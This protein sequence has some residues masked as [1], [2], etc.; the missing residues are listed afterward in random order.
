MS[1][2]GKCR[3][4]WGMRR[5]IVDYDPLLGGMTRFNLGFVEIVQILITISAGFVIAFSILIMIYNLF[6]SAESGARGWGQPVALAFT[7]M[8][9]PVAH[10]RAQLSP[11]A[12]CGG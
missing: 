8:A 6:H 11:S 10:S 9:D 2:W 4:A 5:R 7:R 12:A 1:R 3:W